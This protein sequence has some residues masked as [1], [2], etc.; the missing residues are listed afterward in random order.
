MSDDKAA[1]FMYY[2]RLFG[3]AGPVPFAEF[4]FHPTRR[5]RFDFAIPRYKL[6]IEIDGGQWALHGGR[7]MTDAD[8]EKQNAA[9]VLGWRVMHFS[10]QQLEKDPD[11]CIEQV[12]KALWR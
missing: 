9:A 4:K 5:W 3:P 10:P 12:V 2:W 7:H 11:G 1:L 6:A 8:R